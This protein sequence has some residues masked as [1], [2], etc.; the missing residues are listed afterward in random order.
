MSGGHRSISQASLSLA[1]EVVLALLQSLVA[2]HVDGQDPSRAE[3]P[4]L[5]VGAPQHSRD[6]WGAWVTR[7]GG[8]GMARSKH[9]VAENFEKD[10]TPHARSIPVSCSCHSVSKHCS[11]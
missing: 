2:D 5:T 9:L 1:S 4:G 3:G 6:R 7:L 10:L 11:A 8:E